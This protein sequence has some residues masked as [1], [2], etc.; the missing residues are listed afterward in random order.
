[1]KWI[2]RK[3]SL[4][5]PPGWMSNVLE[6]LYGTP[7][8]L[9]ALI[10]KL[11]NEELIK[12]INNG[13]SV[14]EHIGHLLDLEELHAGRIDDFINRQ[15]ELRGADMQNLKTLGNDHNSKN[16][17]KLMDGFS[18]ACLKFTGRLD[19]LNDAT[20]QFQSIHPRL[21]VK[22]RPV[23]MAYFTAEHDDHHLASIRRLMLVMK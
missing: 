7:I 19:S 20:Q 3:F 21:Q 15:Q 9:L 13:W 23:D 6:R 22:M 18:S 11:K 2:D 10:S 5:L 4:D 1:M 12:R 16:L 8:R 14:Q 17:T